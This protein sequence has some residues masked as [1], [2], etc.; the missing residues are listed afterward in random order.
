MNCEQK[1]DLVAKTLAMAITVVWWFI[2]TGNS[3]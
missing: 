1:M 3:F 2:V